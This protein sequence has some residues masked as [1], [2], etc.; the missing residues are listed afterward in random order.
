MTIGAVRYLEVCL[1][2]SLIGWTLMDYF[3]VLYCSSSVRKCRNLRSVSCGCIAVVVIFRLTVFCCSCELLLYCCLVC[4]GFV[5]W[6]ECSLC[7]GSFVVVVDEF[8]GC[9]QISLRCVLF[10]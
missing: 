8:L 3:Y 1:K 10:A 9:K 6:Y 5:C 2:G 4:V 7:F